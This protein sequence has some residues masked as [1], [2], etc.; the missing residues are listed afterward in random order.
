MKKAEMMATKRAVEDAARPLTN[1]TLFLLAATWD[2]PRGVG[3]HRR[4]RDAVDAAPFAAILNHLLAD[5]ARRK[6]IADKLGYSGPQVT[7][8]ASGQ[9]RWVH[10]EFAR[11][12][13]EVFG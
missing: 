9:T 2:Q 12:M 1:L 8:V 13:K 10:R 6:D 11:K 5:G 7:R 3:G 4:P